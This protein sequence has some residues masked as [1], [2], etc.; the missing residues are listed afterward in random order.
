MFYPSG[1]NDSIWLTTF[2]QQLCAKTAHESFDI[3][4]VTL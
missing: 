4:T 2:C 1:N 3:L